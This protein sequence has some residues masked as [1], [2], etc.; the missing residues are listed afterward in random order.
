[1][2]E[3]WV[4]KPLQ[5]KFLF[6]ELH[7][8]TVSFPSLNLERHFTALTREPA[9]L[10]FEAFSRGLD[11]LQIRSYPTQEPLPRLTLLPQ[12]IRY[13]PQQ[14]RRYYIELQGSFAEYLNKFSSKSRSTLL[15]KVRRFAAASGGQVCWREYR[16][17]DEM[18]EFYCLA[19]QVSQ[20]TY[21]ERLLKAGLPEEPRFQEELREL[22]S[23]DQV[24]GYLLF[25]GA[26]PIAYLCC[27]AQ[28][29]ILLYR[30]LGYLPQ[31]RRWSP[32]TV[33]QY[34]VL[35][36][37]FAE[38]RF[39]LFDFTQGEGQHKEFFATGSQQCA[40]IYYFRKTLR[41]MLLLCLHAGSQTLSE[42]AGKALG[43][44]GLKQWI[45]RFIR[46]RA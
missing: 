7:L 13:V 36:R 25:H 24:R 31:Y 30:Y 12:A 2:T 29:D 16:R 23:R 9:P 45:K 43:F 21:Q 19:R 34:L 17:C 15:R 6:G 41:I 10:P 38:G 46:A 14:Y 40:D 32:G 11:V 28:G 26:Q 33:L 39:R 22:A 5:L 35:E 4:A 37:L 44:L 20:Q 42:M 8:F 1:M 18:A 27:P 3:A